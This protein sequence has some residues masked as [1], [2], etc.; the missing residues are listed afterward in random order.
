MNDH[1]DD[2]SR[3]LEVLLHAS[4]T[5]L[6]KNQLCA[7]LNLDAATFANVITHLE[8]RLTQSVLCLG[9]SA[10]GYRLQIQAQ[11]SSLIQAVWPKKQ[12]KLS[13]AL[14]ET[15]SI[16]AYKQPVTRADIEFIRGVSVSSGVLRQLFDKEWI[17]EKGYR[18]VPGRPA[19]LHTTKT[20]LD[21]FG[22]NNLSEL[23]PL[24]ALKP[25]QQP[26][27]NLQTAHTTGQHLAATQ[28]NL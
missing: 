16:I 25:V 6:T 27:T 23:P 18:D 10:S 26:L 20:F 24:P 15:I 17:K 28:N 1:T 14:L 12:E 13:Q 22:L 3:Q 7:Y 21:A 9:C 8:A 19:L 4:D 2:V 5:P 11:Y